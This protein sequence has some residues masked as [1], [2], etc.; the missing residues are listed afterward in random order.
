[1]TITWT[2]LVPTAGGASA[3]KARRVVIAKGKRAGKKGKTRVVPVRPT[4]RGRAILR[5]AK[6]LKVTLNV[7]FVG[8]VATKSVP[9]TA[10][11]GSVPA[12]APRLNQHSSPL[13]L[14]VA[15]RYGEP[16]DYRDYG[17]LRGLRGPA[18]GPRS[19]RRRRSRRRRAGR[20]QADVPAQ[21][22]AA[23]P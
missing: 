22:L 2:A 9:A 13:G 12:Q 5:R 1:M 21:A 11:A 14:R 4:K 23:T 16:G 15:A 7:K 18:P 8:G 3:A 19:L 17:G 6:S 10:G 20:R